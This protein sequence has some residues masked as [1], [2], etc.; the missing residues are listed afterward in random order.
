MEIQAST[1]EISPIFTSRALL[2]DAKEAAQ[3]ELQVETTVAA[4]L[5]ITKLATFKASGRSS[6]CARI[7]AG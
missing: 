2:Q 6:G 7:M 5:V 4:P 1:E 3:L